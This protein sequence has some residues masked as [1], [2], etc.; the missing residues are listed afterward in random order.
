MIKYILFDLD[1]TLYPTSAGQMQEISQRMSEFMVAQVG[2]PPADVDRVRR[3]YWSRYGTTLRGLYIE[4][5]ID[6]QAFLDYVHDVDL[7]KYLR[8]DRR[9]GA[10][11]AVLPQQKS[12]F[13][14]A[15]AEYARRVLRALGVERHFGDIFDI[16]FINYES[17]PAPAAYAKVAA[18]L[19]VR[20]EECLMIDDTAR[21][22]VP[23]KALGMQ[24]VWLDGN[25]NPRAAEGSQSADYVVKTVYQVAKIHVLHDPEG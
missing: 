8:P 6:A 22:L 5:H 21:N 9:L 4:R 25:D 13:T 16:N 24:T 18:A 10:M 17:K 19:P 7:T 1:D 14:N 12:V 11:L 2:I 3:D 23:A 20:V 15:P